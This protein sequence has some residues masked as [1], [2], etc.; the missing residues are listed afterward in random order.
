MRKQLTIFDSDVLDGVRLPQ[1]LILVC[2]T[3]EWKHNVLNQSLTDSPTHTHGLDS[4]LTELI[5][6]HIITTEL[7]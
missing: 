6:A 3:H 1:I 2:V 7:K 4:T 5:V